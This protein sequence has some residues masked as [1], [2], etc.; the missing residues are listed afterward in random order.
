M[1]ELPQLQYPTTLLNSIFHYA[2][3]CPHFKFNNSTSPTLTKCMEM[4]NSTRGGLRTA[5]FPFSTYTTELLIKVS[6]NFFSLCNV[7]YLCI[8]LKTKQHCKN[9]RQTLKERERWSLNI[10]SQLMTFPFCG[11]V[12]NNKALH[13]PSASAQVSFPPPRAPSGSEI[14][15]YSGEVSEF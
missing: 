13:L 7:D 15:L 10:Y 1:K 11:L 6:E 12:R 2:R 14:L 9:L 8:C 4:N 3:P 5:F